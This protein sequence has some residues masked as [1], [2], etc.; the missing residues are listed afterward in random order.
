M[1]KKKKQQKLIEK[2][3]LSQTKGLKKEL[4]YQEKI[5]KETT[6]VE[7]KSA[8]NYTVGYITGTLFYKNI[9]LNLIKMNNKELKKYIK[10]NNK[11]KKK[12]K[13]YLKDIFKKFKN[14]KEEN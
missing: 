7:I 10:D 13:K 2:I 12:N 11:I 6:D 9:F 14:G 8:A 5:V 1:K 4:K 3:I